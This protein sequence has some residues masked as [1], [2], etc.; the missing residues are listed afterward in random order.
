MYNQQTMAGIKELFRGRRKNETFVDPR[1]DESVAN[2]QTLKENRKIVQ[3]QYIGLR[4][5]QYGLMRSDMRVRFAHGLRIASP[6]HIHPSDLNGLVPKDPTWFDT[7]KELLA[8]HFEMESTVQPK[9][10]AI[11]LRRHGHEF[12]VKPGGLGYGE[13]PTPSHAERNTPKKNPYFVDIRKVSIADILYRN[14]SGGG[15][16]YTQ[17]FR[18]A[19]PCSVRGRYEHFTNGAKLA[20]FGLLLYFDR[21]IQQRGLIVGGAYEGESLGILLPGHIIT[22]HIHGWPI[23]RLEPNSLYVVDTSFREN[24]DMVFDLI[25][26]Q[27]I[28]QEIHPVGVLFEP[29]KGRS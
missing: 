10:Q 23:G 6:H 15:G 27:K 18:Q 22:E 12:R 3:E 24:F 4:T 16:D 11:T 26:A 7:H 21:D 17:E 2:L 8:T 5:M 29:A 28:F 1:F 25:K 20:L 13:Y 9:E 14:F 19:D